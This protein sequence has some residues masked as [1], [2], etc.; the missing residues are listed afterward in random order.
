M[1][2]NISQELVNRIECAAANGSKVAQIIAKEIKRGRNNTSL[3]FHDNPNANYFDS[4]RI[5]GT[6]NG[7]KTLRIV[8]TCCT[9]DLND[10]RFP[11]K[12]NPNSP[13]FKENRTELSPKT[14]AE[15]FSAYVKACKSGEIT[16]DDDAYFDSAIR[17]PSKVKV[18][19]SERMF[20]IYNAYLEENYSSV[21]DNSSS[22]LHGSC[23]RYEDKARNAADFY[24]NFC[25][26]GIIFARDAD[27]NILGR[28]IVWKNVVFQGIKEMQSVVD[29]MYFC[30]GFV[31][32]MM[33]NYAQSIGI[34]FCKTEN[35]YSS[36]RKFT[37]LKQMFMNGIDGIDVTVDAWQKL[38]LD[39]YITVPQ[40][41]WHKKGAPYCDTF[42]YLYKD[43]SNNLY[44][45][46]STDIDWSGFEGLDMISEFRNTSGYASKV[47]SICPV[48]GKVNDSGLEGGICRDCFKELFT[49]TPFGPAIIGKLR[50]F[51]G[52]ML[53]DKCFVNGKPKSSLELWHSVKKLYNS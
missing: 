13:Y 15:L 21:A 43:T 23:M 19:Y 1:K 18:V 28:A 14:F 33:L 29:R 31:R 38:I 35:T 24:S 36:Q 12:C 40:I 10:D 9:K 25:G 53:P 44:I 3:I 48:C 41:K 2:L 22:N 17:V 34:S 47:K 37:A 50:K 27:G 20:D 46:N 6:C 30:F 51:K 32:N 39:A 11:D 26:A 45:S 49:D 52:M 7:Y 4:K 42:H 5:V 8:I 16:S